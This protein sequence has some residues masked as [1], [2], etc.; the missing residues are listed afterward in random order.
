L[1]Y[2]FK[3]KGRKK[4]VKKRFTLIELL[5]V[6]A[7]I[8]ILAAI[9]LPALNSARER[10]R[11]AACINNLKQIGTAAAMY[12]GDNEDFFPFDRANSSQASTEIFRFYTPYLGEKNSGVWYCPSKPPCDKTG[13]TIE[14]G[15]GANA[16]L[17]G[18]N[19]YLSGVT[20]IRTVPVKATKVIN[21]SVVLQVADGPYG[22][23][24]S[25]YMNPYDQAIEIAGHGNQNQP[26]LLP[27]SAFYDPAHRHNEKVNYLAVAGNVQT[28][29]PVTLMTHQT[30]SYK[31]RNGQK[32]TYWYSGWWN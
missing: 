12:Q 24:G 4:M 15:Y 31:A 5:V 32:Y 16:A 19:Y 30:D 2:N 27:S 9:L 10:G 7:I 17:G 14:R 28:I 26:F 8:A 23:T 18:I 25:R 13:C 1:K 3:T 22:G 6:I 20:D 11:S 29:D 21:A